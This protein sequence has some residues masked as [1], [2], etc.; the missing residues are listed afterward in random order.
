MARHYD[1][2]AEYRAHLRRTMRRERQI[3][4]LDWAALIGFFLFLAILIGVMLY[5][6][7]D[8][9]QRTPQSA[10]HPTAQVAPP[11]PAYSAPIPTLQPAQAEIIG[12]QQPHAIR[13]A[14]P[15]PAPVVDIPAPEFVAPVELPPAAPVPTIDSAQVTVIGARQSNGCAPGETF[16]PRSGCHATGSGGAMPGP[17]GEGK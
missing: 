16:Y 14:E 6:R 11:A 5:L 13:G 2:D 15:T 3:T 7:G 4:A 1:D 17:V 10:P 8:I 12:A 9:S